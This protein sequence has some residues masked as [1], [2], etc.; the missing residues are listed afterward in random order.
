MFNIDF[1]KL[2]V[3]LLPWFFRKPVWIS[4][5]GALISPV[6][7]LYINFLSFRDM[8]LYE[9]RYNGQVAELEYV[10]NDFYYGDGTLMR[11]YIEDNTESGEIYLYNIAENEDE[12]YIYNVNEASEPEI[13]IFNTSEGTGGTDFI[14]FVPD[15]LVYDTDYLRGLVRKYKIAGPTFTIQNYSE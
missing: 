14:V 4:W 1:H 2:V 15:T 3:D 5:L 8:R 11:I 9:S 12:T 13:Y 6:G 10:L 7:S